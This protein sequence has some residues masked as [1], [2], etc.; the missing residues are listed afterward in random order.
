M[1]IDNT[2]EIFSRLR[3]RL[4]D[5]ETMMENFDSAPGQ[6][7]ATISRIAVEGRS[8]TNIIQNLRN[9]VDGFDDW[10]N[11]KVDE[12]RNDA[13]L[14]F[15]Y[16]LRTETL[17]EGK[18]RIRGLQM[19]PQPNA[20]IQIESGKGITVAKKLASGEVHST[21]FPEPENTKGTFMGDSNGGCGF[22][23]VTADGS[24][25]KKYIHIPSEVI[26]VSLLFERPPTMH[27]G[28]LLADATPRYLC[29]LYVRYLQKLCLEAEKKFVVT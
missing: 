27:N 16:Q 9:K 3:R 18:D 8:I 13:L 10:Y 26:E 21:F 28:Q 22:N 17:K 23:V 24:I 12:M 11:V 14:R 15:F 6:M 1:P 29:Q 20:Q 19:K 2:S 25:R 5:I 7:R 4:V